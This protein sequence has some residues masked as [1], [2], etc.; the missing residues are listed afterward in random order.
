MPRELI[1]RK[2]ALQSGTSFADLM[3]TMFEGTKISIQMTAT[4]FVKP[5]LAVGDSAWE[6]TGLP[7]MEGE[8]PPSKG[9]STVVAVKQDGQWLI[10]SH[11]SRVPAAPPGTDR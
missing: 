5:D 6:I 10:T 3:S 8:T 7:E 1:F 9:T 11:R 4:R 2:V